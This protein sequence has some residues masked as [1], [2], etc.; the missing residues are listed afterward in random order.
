M[1]F[2]IEYLYSSFRTLLETLRRG[3]PR[4]AQFLVGVAP[5][6]AAYA[7]FG[8]ALFAETGVDYRFGSL[9]DALITLFAVLNGDVV[10][11]AFDF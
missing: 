10:R 4:V 9:T 7:L 2:L 5:I 11:G 3:V 6:Y 8:V 1:S